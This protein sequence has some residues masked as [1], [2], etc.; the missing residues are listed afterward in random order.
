M[1]QTHEDLADI[2]QRGSTLEA[3]FKHNAEI[4]SHNHSSDNVSRQYNFYWQMPENF[5]WIGKS[6]K[7]EPRVRHL[8][9]IG[10]I[11]NVNFV[12]QPELYHLR[13]LLFH[14]KDATSFE[15][16]R[17]VTD[18]QYQTYKQACLA[19]GLTYD[20]Q[21]WIE[22]LQESA[23]FKMPVAMRSLFV[24]ILIYGS[25][26]N[27]KRLWETFQENLSEDFIHAARQNGQPIE[28][29]I[30]RAYRIIAKK[31]NTEATEGR[32]FQYWV[33]TFGFEDIHNYDLEDNQDNSNTD[34]SAVLGQQMYQLLKGK[35]IEV[36]NSILQ[37]VN[38]TASETK[39][40]FI[41]GPGGTGK[42]FIYKTLYY[43]L[44]GKRYKVKC[45]AFTGIASIL[46]PNGRTSHKTF[47]MKV[48]LTPDSVSSIKPNSSKARLLA[49]IDIFLMDEA[50]MLPKYGLHSIDQL[51]RSIGNSDLPFGGKV[52]VLGGDFRQCLPVQPRANKT[53][54]LDLSIKRSSLWSLFKTFK[55]EENMRVDIEQR[56]FADYL[57]QLGNGEL[58]LNAMEEIELPQ[59]FISSNNLIDE[60][61]GN[62]LA[63]ENYDGMKDRAIL[64]PLNK[65]VE[66]INDDIVAKLP[67][68]YKT[69]YSHDSMKDQ[70]E[71]AVEFTTEF[72]NSVNIS[73]L[74]PHELKLKKNT[75]IM[76]LR[77]LDVSEGLCNG[78]RL[79]VTSLC[80][81]IIKAKIV[82]GEQS[83]KEVHIPRI[84]LDSSKG[85]LGCTMQRH[86]FP[87]R[88]AF[89]MTVHKS[90]G[91]TFES[92]GV[93]LKS[94][95]V[96]MHGMLYVAFSRVKRPT[97]LKVNLSNENP[98]H[99]R[100][101]VWKQVLD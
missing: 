96:F 48:P 60:V 72:L 89:A 71:G 9:V 42:T 83:G 88:S 63:N 57:L 2:G 69:Y 75:L 39:C 28:N 19:R 62:C 40:F 94:S 51:L 24:Q 33:Q 80:N 56:Q 53:E 67:G 78:V 93:D 79:M 100:N 98:R 17:T 68:E 55:L 34:E 8:R 27:P 46:L 70:P 47:G 4:K 97:T 29:A 90:Q 37:A 7:W 95:P 16:L 38:N 49:E 43:M 87:V 84:T 25:P 23:L 36:V 76:L 11:H 18:I 61:F 32:N 31:L 64:A 77:N 73:D 26:E 92:V 45:M 3:Y 41:D 91:Q 82:T 14:V 21:Q 44:T 10:R 86:Q 74:P 1:D 101:I 52:I 58:T 13:L 65:D 50:P 6:S 81:H 20:D 22:G 30:N 59:N 12:A 5:K 54:L 15:D 66:K 85:Q 35:Q 99:T